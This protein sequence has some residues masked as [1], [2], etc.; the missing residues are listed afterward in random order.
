MRVLALLLMLLAAAVG[1]AAAQTVRL[2]NTESQPAAGCTLDSAGDVC[3]VPMAG[4]ASALVRIPSGGTLVATI[5][6]VIATIPNP[7]ASDWIEGKAWFVASD[8]TVSTS[9]VL[10][11]PNV[12]VDHRIVSPVPALWMGVK[13]PTAGYTSG[14]VA[15]AKIWAVVQGAPQFLVLNVAGQPIVAQAEDL[16]N[17]VFGL[18]V[19]INHVVVTRGY[20]DSK[21]ALIDATNE[22]VTI[23]TAGAGQVTFDVPSGL[24]GEIRFECRMGTGT[25]FGVEVVFTDNA[26]LA[27]DVS[28][29][30]FPKRGHFVKTGFTECR[31]RG[32]VV[33]SGSVTPRLEVSPGTGA[34]TLLP[35][36]QYLGQVQ[37]FPT[38]DANAAVGLS[39][40]YLT[41]AASTNSTNIKASAGRISAVH[42]VNTTGTTYYLRWYNLSAAPTCSSATGFVGTIPLLATSSAG[43]SLTVGIGFSTGIGYCVTGGGSSTDN[44]NAATGIY[45]WHDFK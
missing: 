7:G 12:A 40:H 36:S 14:S 34:V 28:L 31:I 26:S 8:N 13:I 27:A 2:G 29:T 42:V 16:G 20:N 37:A 19:A 1:P 38:A 30:S 25:Y 45:I 43:R 15:T 32:H 9:I 23:N 33:T 4:Q 3:G 39:T 18:R 11:N 10:T 17:G 6:P 44:T 5:V 21:E 35:G 22:A 24:T 41:S